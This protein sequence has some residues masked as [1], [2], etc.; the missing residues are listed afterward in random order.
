MIAVFDRGWNRLSADTYIT[1]A[2]S[3]GKNGLRPSIAVDSGRVYAGNDD[4][5]RRTGLVYVFE[6]AQPARRRAVAH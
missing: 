5:A 3:D 1:L 4:A 6:L 2:G